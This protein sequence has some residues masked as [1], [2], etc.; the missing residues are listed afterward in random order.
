[1]LYNHFLIAEAQRADTPKNRRIK[2]SVAYP[3][4]GV[5]NCGNIPHGIQYVVPTAKL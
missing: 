4:S 1:M 2:I 3:V 5:F